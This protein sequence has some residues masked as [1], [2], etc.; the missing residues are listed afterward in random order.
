MTTYAHFSPVINREHVGRSLCC[1]KLDDSPAKCCS[2][3]R[4]S[5]FS[6]VM[7]EMKMGCRSR[8][9]LRATVAW[10]VLKFRLL[11]KVWIK[12]QLIKFRNFCRWY[13]SW[14]FLIWLLSFGSATHAPRSHIHWLTMMHGFDQRYSPS[15][16]LKLTFFKLSFFPR[17]FG[18]K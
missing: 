13:K 14:I 18:L 17:R 3:L 8:I 9:D 5:Q 15:K 7:S 6:S 10:P 1:W 4:S 12:P 2:N 16:K 11:I